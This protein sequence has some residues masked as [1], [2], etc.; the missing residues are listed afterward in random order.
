M[1]LTNEQIAEIAKCRVDPI[2]FILR[3]GRI[4]HPD[5]GIIPFDLYEYQKNV[6]KRMLENRFVIIVKGRQMGLSTLMSA[7]CVWLACFFN[8]KEILILANKGT[9]ATNL[10]KKCKLFLN[11]IPEWLVPAQINDNMQSINLENQSVIQSSTTNENAARSEALSLLIFDEAAMIKNKLVEEVWTSARP[12]LATGGSAVVL[13]TPKGIGN[14]FHSQWEKAEA[15]DSNDIATF[16]PI[17]LHWSLHP[18]RDEAW[19]ESEKATMTNTTWEQEYCCS[20]TKS[21]NTVIEADTI[22]WYEKEH[23][24]EPISKEA[25]DHNFWVWKEP[26]MG[27]NYIVSAD[28]SRG[29]A[30]DYSTIIV[31]CVED[32]E[33]VAEY[34]GKINPSSFGDLLT[35]VGTRYNNAMIVCENNSIG[36]AA[37]QR[38]LDYQYPK[39]YWSKKIEGQLFFDPLNWSIP[40]PDKIPGFST[41]PKNR[42]LVVNAFAEALT[43]K[44]YIFH[45]SRLLNEIKGFIWVNT[46]NQVRAQAAERMHDDLVMAL[47][48]GIF[49]RSI[50]LRLTSA[51]SIQTAALLGSISIEKG[52][53]SVENISIQQESVN[54]GANKNPFIV[55]GEDLSYLVG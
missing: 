22:D 18:D 42:P 8:A 15:G 46:G 23:I 52:R 16:F 38:I 48:I 49:V 1:Q 14:W 20:F 54:K 36:Y 24:Y 30:S 19:A 7:Y 13:S 28:V 4:K 55:A 40:G 27:K 17:K 21:G 10:I 53:H 41:G 35:T 2:Y 47:A 9:V 32:M 5:K 12:T 45:S 37:I 50:T 25:F 26:E 33:Q 44:Q 31:T 43:Q 39:I 3:Y 51:D 29:D 34:R 6:I 11:N